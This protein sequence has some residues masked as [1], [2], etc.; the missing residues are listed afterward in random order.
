[1]ES[2]EVEQLGWLNGS[3]GSTMEQTQSVE[4]PHQNSSNNGQPKLRDR[5]CILIRQ[6]NLDP[7]L[8]KAYAAD[9]CGTPTLR[10]ANRGLVE[11]SPQSRM[12]VSSL[13]HPRDSDGVPF[14]QPPGS[15][16]SFSFERGRRRTHKIPGLLDRPSAISLRE[17]SC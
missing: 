10:E 17:S 11:L 6:Y 9:F 4:S 15:L 16:G 7:I 13:L 12:I 2:F 5:L 1:L 14:S 3:P 8:V